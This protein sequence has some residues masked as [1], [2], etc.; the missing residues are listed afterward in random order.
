MANIALQDGKVV[1]KDGKASCSCCGSII[2]IP[3]RDC[4]PYNDN[5]NFS[6]SG[7]QVTITAEFQ[8]PPDIQYDPPRIC[9]D[10]W[11]AYGPGYGGSTNLYQIFLT[12]ASGG[13]YNLTPE[14]PC[15]WILEI[16]VQGMFEWN[17]P[18]GP[19]VCPVLGSAGQI[20]TSLNPIG[21]Y[22]FLIYETCVPPDETSIRAFNFTVTIS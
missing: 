15:C 13:F 21:S 9:G 3:C 8:Y 12:R 5:L 19:D 17:S 4:P 14:I 18:V 11:D 10:S 1:L 22:N 7:D 20:I 2:T 6:F 16:A